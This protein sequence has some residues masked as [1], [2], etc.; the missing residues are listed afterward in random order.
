MAIAELCVEDGR[1]N[2][3]MC[4]QFT[5]QAS[6]FKYPPNLPYAGLYAMLA[7]A[8]STSL[9]EKQWASSFWF[10]LGATLNEKRFLR[11]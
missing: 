5:Q 11:F 9:R 10:Q 2:T 4:L 7:L 3:D 6:L 1:V 8:V